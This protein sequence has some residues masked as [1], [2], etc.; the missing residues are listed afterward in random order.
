M[1]EAY[2]TDDVTLATVVAAALDH[3]DTLVAVAAALDHVVAL[4]TADDE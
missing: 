3:D 4:T 2:L 1:H